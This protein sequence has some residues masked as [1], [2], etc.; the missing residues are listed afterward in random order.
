MTRAALRAF[1][2][3]HRHLCTLALLGTSL[4][5]ALRQAF[6]DVAS[7]RSGA[8]HANLDLAQSVAYVEGVHASYLRWS[9][10]HRLS[11]RVAE[12]GPGDNSGV[13]LLCLASGASQV[14]LADR[15][16][17]VRSNERQKAIYAE[18]LK[19]HPELRKRLGNPVELV[20]ANFKGIVRHYGADAAGERFF[21]Q[22]G[23]YQLI[24]SNAVLEHVYDPL[25]CLRDMSRALA[26]DGR[27]VHQ[28]DLRDHGMYSEY[29]DELTFLTL[30]DRLY[31]A[32]SRPKGLP[33]RVALPQYRAALEALPLDQVQFLVTHLVGGTALPEPTPLERIDP[34]ILQPAIARVR[35]IRPKLAASLRR[36]DDRD[37]AVAGFLLTA[38]RPAAA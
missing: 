9:G 38:R 33:N 10:L 27:L 16:Y 12:L 7:T 24:A 25:Q 35:A 32:L 4:L 2:L 30:P 3:R 26:P 13:G 5:A 11:G 20:D 28:V 31:G 15:F 36:F 23:G 17:S 34:A 14:D 22:H 19:R 6:Q 21:K 18:L 8:A 1:V 29:H 37:L